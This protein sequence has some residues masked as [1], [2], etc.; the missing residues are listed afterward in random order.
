M[1]RALSDGEKAAIAQRREFVHEHLPEAV[2]F[3]KQ[4]HELGMIEGWRNVTRV[5][6]IEDAPPE[7]ACCGP[8]LRGDEYVKKGKA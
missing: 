8:F 6:M 2:D 4:L 7:T 1:S 3:V 5:G